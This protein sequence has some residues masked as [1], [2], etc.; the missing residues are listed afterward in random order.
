MSDADASGLEAIPVLFFVRIGRI[1]A[2]STLFGIGQARTFSDFSGGV[3]R[4]G[5]GFRYFGY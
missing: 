4:S 3:A 5:S 2:T 1:A